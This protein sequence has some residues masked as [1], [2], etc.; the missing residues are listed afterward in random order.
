M[1]ARP[2]GPSRWSSLWSS[3]SWRPNVAGLTTIAV[4]VA[5]WEVLIRGGIL[6]YQYLPAPSA[7]A[8]GAGELVISGELVAATLHTLQ[9]M[10]LGWAIA[11][12]LGVSFG[13]LLGSSR[14]LRRYSLASIEVLRP[15]PA[16]AFVPVAM[17][18]FGFSIETE[19]MVIVLPTLWPMLINTMGGMMG[20]HA[21]LHDVGRTFRLPRAAVIRKILLPAAA[22]AIVVGARISL[23]L[24]LVLAVLAEMVGNPE[25]LGYE[26]VQQQQALRPDL[27]FAYVVVIGLLGIALNGILLGLVS[28]LWPAGAAALR[29]FKS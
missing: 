13:L 2:P 14:L 29:G 19:L 5:L 25:G 3:L 18:L 9:S 23:T 10:F 8:A 12:V 24:A 17:V 20:I 16:I 4:C 28:A 1:N 6:R 26:V 27:M 7:I 11:V 22:P 21:R 15:M